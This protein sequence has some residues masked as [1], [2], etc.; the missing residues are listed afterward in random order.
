RVALGGG[1]SMHGSRLP[2]ASTAVTAPALSWLA[3]DNREN[4]I[5]TPTARIT[6]KYRGIPSD[7]VLRC[8]VHRGAFYGNLQGRAQ[9]PAPGALRNQARERG[10]RRQGI[11][12]T[13]NSFAR[14]R[15]SNCS[16]AATPPGG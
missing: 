5:S 7:S 14:C 16:R 6:H 1:R 9:L 12:Q 4:S 11:S 2:L 8:C 3:N 13:S 15:P 10:P